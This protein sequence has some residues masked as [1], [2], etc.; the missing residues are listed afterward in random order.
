MK[1]K[2]L[3]IILV[4]PLLSSAQNLTGIWRGNFYQRVFGDLSDKYKY[5]VQ[6]DHRKSGMIEGVTYSYRTTVFY[7]K[8]KLS[9]LQNVSPGKFTLEETRI[10]EV[11][12]QQNTEPCVMTCFL[13]Y[14]KQG[15]LE[16]LRGS[17]TSKN[18]YDGKD[19]GNGTVYLTKVTT[20]DFHKEKF[21]EKKPPVTPPPANNKPVIKP[22]VK[23]VTPPV[24]KPDTPKKP[25]VNPPLQKPDPGKVV[26]I[27]PQQKPVTNNTIKKNDLKINNIEKPAVLKTRENELVKTIM[28]SSSNE[29][30]IDIYDNGE[31][32]HDTVSVYLDNKL[33]LSRQM[34]RTI[35]LSLTLKMDETNDYHEIVMVAENLGEIPPNTSLMV[36]NAGDKR[37]EVR[38]TSTE[39]KNAVIR[40]KYEKPK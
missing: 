31:I 30:K 19:C 10:V 36:V 25:V 38:V 40:F 7:G 39:Q 3:T 22:P 26:K 12:M 23:P 37:Y 29:V 15:D 11:K 2:L 20:S 5:E 35:P 18:V 13:T 24:T 28:I 6:I 1:L 34:L 14:S 16:I 17:Y 9:G 8:A 33:V 4:L 32:D 27:D 21:L